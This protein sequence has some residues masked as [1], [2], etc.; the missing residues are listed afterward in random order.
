MRMSNTRRT[1]SRDRRRH[2]LGR[3]NGK[4][5][6][7]VISEDEDEDWKEKNVSQ[8][9]SVLHEN[10]FEFDVKLKVWR[11]SRANL[12]RTPSFD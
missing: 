1:R 5:R 8:D 7:E 11:R 9:A 6:P 10:A 3:I 4:G 2:G 12:W